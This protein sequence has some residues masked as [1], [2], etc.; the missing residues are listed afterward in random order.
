MEWNERVRARGHNACELSYC[1]IW[2]QDSRDWKGLEDGKG[3]WIAPLKIRTGRDR[4]LEAA[5]R[6]LQ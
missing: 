1:C 2:T 3:V 4:V 6:A 5:L